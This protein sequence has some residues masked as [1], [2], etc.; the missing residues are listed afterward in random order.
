MVAAKSTGT[1][2]ENAGMRR[3]GQGFLPGR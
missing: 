2:D 3:T 1:A